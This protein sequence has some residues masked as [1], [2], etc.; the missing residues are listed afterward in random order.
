MA[1]LTH[2]AIDEDTLG[3]CLRER[4]L[5]R[6][7]GILLERGLRPG[8]WLAEHAAAQLSRTSG[9]TSRPQWVA[10]RAPSCGPADT[11][12]PSE[13][14]SCASGAAVVAAA[15]PQTADAAGLLVLW[16]ADS[17][18][19]RRAVLA[20]QLRDWVP[21]RVLLP[22]AMMQQLERCAREVE[23]GAVDLQ[24]FDGPEAGGGGA[25][26][27]L[28]HWDVGA[29]LA[30]GS[31]VPVAV[32][33]PPRDFEAWGAL[34]ELHGGELAALRARRAAAA[35]EED[36]EA[37]RRISEF[38]RAILALDPDATIDAQPAGRR[39]GSYALVVHC[40]IDGHNAGWGGPIDVFSN[41]AD[42]LRAIRASCS[43]C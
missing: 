39:A 10:W 27:A 21:V 3:K 15:V 22:H 33:T 9:C 42:L 43:C 16:A 40:C 13:E 17:R 36:A 23:S 19:A 4:Q 37:R 25:P 30:D 34:R 38:S 12:G 2:V 8:E 35:E 41:V 31:P 5:D 14:V 28:P 20:L 24:L 29:T 7:E 11:V 26:P 18:A 32:R 1:K 6:L